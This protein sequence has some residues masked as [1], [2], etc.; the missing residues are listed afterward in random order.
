MNPDLSDFIAHILS[1]AMLL[2]NDRSLNCK[3]HIML[4][5]GLKSLNKGEVI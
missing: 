1:H 4:P 3:A 2:I 5:L